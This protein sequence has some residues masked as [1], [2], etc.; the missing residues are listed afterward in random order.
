MIHLNLSRREKYYVGVAS[1]IIVILLFTQLVIS[2]LNKKRA[3]LERSLA[4]KTQALQDMRALHDEFIQL[5]ESADMAQSKFSQRSK[6]FDLNKY[7]YN[8][9]VELSIGKNVSTMDPDTDTVGSLTFSIVKLKFK[10]ITTKQ[11]TNYLHRV[12][13]SGNNLFVNRMDISQTS[14]PT[15]YIDV[16]LEV[17][18]IVS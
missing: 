7:L 3:R 2:P 14:K 12:E 10:A 17:E 15:G 6:N 5:E 9:A 4:E 16:V 1:G 18:T 11:L 8:L 13:C